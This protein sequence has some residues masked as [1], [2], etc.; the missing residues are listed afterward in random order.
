M[1]KLIPIFWNFRLKKTCSQFIQDP[2]NSIQIIQNDALTINVVENQSFVQI[3]PQKVKL[4]L[5]LNRPIK[6]NFKVIQAKQYPVDVYYLMDLSNSMSDDKDTI[7]R[8][9]IY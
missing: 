3:S 4:K 5:R 9:G 7:V 6:L 1:Q 8:L 2:E